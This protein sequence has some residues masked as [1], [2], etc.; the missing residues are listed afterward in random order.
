VQTTRR[1]GG[2]TARPVGSASVDLASAGGLPVRSGLLHLAPVLRG[3]VVTGTRGLERV[4]HA[5]IAPFRGGQAGA[6]R[7]IACDLL[8]VS[9][10]WN[11]AMHLFSQ[12]RG[13]LRYDEG[14]GAFLPGQELD[15]LSITGAAAGVFDLAGC[16]A[17][18]Q[19]AARTALAASAIEPA[20]PVAAQHVVVVAEPARGQAARPAR[21]GR[22]RQ[23]AVRRAEPQIAD[24][25]A[26]ESGLPAP[27]ARPSKPGRSGC[28]HTR[29]GSAAMMSLPPAQAPSSAAGFRSRRTSRSTSAAARS[30]SSGRHCD[31]VPPIPVT[32]QT[33]P[34]GCGSSRAAS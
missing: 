28:S 29:T 20:G 21:R 27:G 14:L 15:G 9:G 5:L 25:P 32:R 12:A 30:Q 11:P 7:A 23:H 2:R 3:S 34:S 19:Q 16:L 24:P 17:S 1:R 18:G 26:A 4:T 33:A 31:L 6:A 13:Q 10:G 8:L 22:H